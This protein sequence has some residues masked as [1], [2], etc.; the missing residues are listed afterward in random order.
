MHSLK[1]REVEQV[2]ESGGEGRGG[3]KPK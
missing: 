2:D 1:G 3:R